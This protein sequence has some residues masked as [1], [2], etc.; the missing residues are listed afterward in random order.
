MAGNRISAK[1]ALELLEEAVH[2]LRRTPLNVLAL[3][4]LGALPFVLGFLYFWADLSQS[5]FASGRT[6]QMTIIVTALFFWMKTWQSIFTSELRAQV[7][8]HASPRWTI[9]R[10]TR[11]AI[12]QM[13]VQ[14]SGLFILPI[15][16]IIALPFGW[17]YA[18]YQSVTALGDGELSAVRPLLKRASNQAGLWIGQNHI[19]LLVLVLFGLFVSL[20]LGTAL[21]VVPGLIKTFLGIET[22]FTRSGIH[23]IFN[24]TFLAATVGLSY[25]AV[26]PL[27]KTAYVLR[28]FYGESLSSGQDL[29]VELKAHSL[30]AQTAMPVL[31]C[32]FVLF[33]S[34]AP[35]ADIGSTPAGAQP[36][37]A[38]SDLNLSIE[39][40]LTK[41]EFTWRL[42]R[43]QQDLPPEQKGWFVT[44]IEGV[45]GTLLGGMKTIR[46]W[47]RGIV[48]WFERRFPTRAPRDGRHSGA[49][50]GWLISLRILI[51]ILLA[52]VAS[53]VAIIFIRLWKRRR[54]KEIIAAQ[55]VAAKPDLT[56]ENI[57]ADQLPEDGWLKLARELMEQGNFRLAL[58]ALYLASLA[59]L[60][61]RE[62]VSIAKF[63]TNRDYE[64]ELRRRARALPELQTAFAQN[65]GAFDRVWYGQHDITPD[66]LQHFQANVER[67]RAC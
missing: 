20:N 18:F 17:A 56:D 50:Y 6:A 10:L 63:K 9:S 47:I 66:N 62:L 13:I 5:A 23:S 25:L 11:V 55:P 65:V 58:R 7:G 51:F 39:R 8:G 67:I 53:A 33:H 3:Y 41:R 61:G 38:A 64:T 21:I 12:A 37:V 59:H 52:L 48:E 30:A 19:L 42:P 15:A 49:G 29:K 28:C 1:G 57:I 54:R 26:D 43:E 32:S 46:D 16:L 24:T 40:V 14:P 44:F 35:A 4:Y 27:I 45:R 60:A 22:V 2:L 31:L 36:S 34:I